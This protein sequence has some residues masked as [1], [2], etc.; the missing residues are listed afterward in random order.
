MS[1][2]IAANQ[3]AECPAL[4]V[5]GGRVQGCAE[6]RPTRAQRAGQ[7]PFGNDSKVIKR[8]FK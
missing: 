8:V 3:S 2:V 4:L 7:E 5:T 1:S 6:A